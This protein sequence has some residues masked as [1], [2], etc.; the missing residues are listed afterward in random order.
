MSTRTHASWDGSWKSTAIRGS[1][2]DQLFNIF[3][4]GDFAKGAHDASYFT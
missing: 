1:I 2:T 4:L 3:R